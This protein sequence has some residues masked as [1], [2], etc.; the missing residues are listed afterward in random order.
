MIGKYDDIDAQIKYE[1]WV[2]EVRA[3]NMKREDVHEKLLT[4]SGEPKV[5]R[6]MNVIDESKLGVVNLTMCL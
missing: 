3:D 6:D 1:Q 4:E 2:H 5:C